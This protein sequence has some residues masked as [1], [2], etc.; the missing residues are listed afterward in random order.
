M[1]KYF[2]YFPKVPY[3]LDDDKNSLDV[4]SNLTSK[5]KFDST[6]KENSVVYYDYVVK[7]GET[8]E[9]ISDKIYGS[10][11]R[12]WIILILNDIIHP[13]IDWP[14]EQNSLI[15]L[16]DKKYEVYANTSNNE[17]GLEWS[18]TNYKEYLVTE[19]IKVLSD[20]STTISINQ[21]T[22]QSYANVVNSTENY[23]LSDGTNV[24]VKKVKSRKTY[25]DYEV[26]VNESKR[27]IKILKNE[28]VPVIEEEF[29]NILK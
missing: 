27:N 21:V 20:N 28:F 3:F 23:L 8:P 18:Q 22:E 14:I 15:K 25:Y 17:T 29:K 10:P 13:Q 6:F 7:D 11:E 12:H 24:E 26:E 16:I 19:T 1:A 5:F 4:V 2:N 9:I